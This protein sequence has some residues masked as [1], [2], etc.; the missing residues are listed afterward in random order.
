M[1]DRSRCLQPQ[2][3]SNGIVSLLGQLWEEKYLSNGALD[4]ERRGKGN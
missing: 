1:A 2:I 3:E 4:K